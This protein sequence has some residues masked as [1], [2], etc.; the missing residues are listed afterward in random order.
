ENVAAGGLMSYGPDLPDQLRQAAFYV[1]RIL[2][3]TKPT[4]LP[5]QQA[6]KIEL[7]INLKTAKALGLTIPPT[8]L[9]LA[10]EVIECGLS[11]AIS[12]RCSAARQPLG[13]SRCA[14]S[15]RPCRWSGSS[16]VG[17][18]TSPHRLW[19]HSAKGWPR[20]ATSRAKMWR[21]HSAGRRVT[22]TDC[23]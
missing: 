19:L 3:G 6:T 5:V 22:T 13:R 9:G 1:D 18:P 15:S 4:D 23:P 8:L 21:S 7:V 12:S 16:A 11:G 2:K 20:R 14:R 10:E 17:R